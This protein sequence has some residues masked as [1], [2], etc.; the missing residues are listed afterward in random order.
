MADAADPVDCPAEVPVVV[1]GVVCKF[2]PGDPVLEAVELPVT[3]ERV[4]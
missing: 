2:T 4:V 3:E 1:L